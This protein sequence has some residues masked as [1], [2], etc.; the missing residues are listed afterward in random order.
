MPSASAPSALS[1]ATALSILSWLR[2]TTATLAPTIARPLAMPRPRPPLPPVMIAPLPVKSNFLFI[3]VLP[4][5]F[6][7]KRRGHPQHASN[8]ANRHATV[9]DDD[10][11]GDE[12]GGIARQ[13]DG[14]ALE[15]IGHAKALNRRLFDD[16]IH[17]GSDL[18]GT[19]AG[20]HLGMH[21]TGQYRV[22]LDV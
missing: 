12:A 22:D 18:V 7:V 3:Q 4:I 14:D 19:E 15:V 5:D 20:H 2:P 9:G 10:G 1:C 16:V 21:Q 11:A 13:Q 8:A 17:Q 6:L